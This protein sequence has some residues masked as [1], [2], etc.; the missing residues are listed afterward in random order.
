MKYSKAICKKCGGQNVEYKAWVNANTGE[1]ISDAM[2]DD[3][4][5][6]C[7]CGSHEGIEF[8]EIES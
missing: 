6:C 7:D 1:I 2:Y 8:K 4:T 3:D 5:W